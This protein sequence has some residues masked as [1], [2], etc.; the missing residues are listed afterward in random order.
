M[1]PGG[2]T[3]LTFRLFGRD[4]NASRALK[5]V[6]READ[7]AGNKLARLKLTGLGLRATA[8]GG[9]LVALPGTLN[10][11]GAAAVGTAGALAAL[12][13]VAAAGGAALGALRL[14]TLGFADALKEIRDPAKFAEQLKYLSPAARDA[15]RGIRSLLPQID[16][17]RLNVQQ[18]FF[19][20]FKGDLKSLAG[21]YLPMLREQLSQIAANVGAGGHG[22][23]DFLGKPAQVEQVRKVLANTGT[24]AGILGQALRPA[25]DALVRLT[26]TGSTFLPVMATAIARA[27][28]ALDQF[29]AASQKSGA[30]QQ[31]MADGINFAGQLGT[32]LLAVGRVV[33]GVFSAAS[34][35]GFGGFADVLTRIAGIVNGPAFQTG[36]STVFGGL[37]SA[38]ASLS[39]VLPQVGSALAAIA[40]AI[41]S[42]VAGFGSGLAATLA[43]TAQLVVTLAPT[44]NALAAAFA[45]LAPTVGPAVAGFLAIQRALGPAAKALE[46]II[47]LGGKLGSLVVAIR[48]VATAFRFLGLALNVNPIFL[49]ITAIGLLAIG[50]YEAYQ[51]SETFRVVVQTAFK[52]AAGV[53]L[54]AVSAILGA[55]SRLF[56]AASHIPGIGRA[57]ASTAGAFASAKGWIDSTR[58]SIAAM[59]THVGVAVDV[60]YNV[61]VSGPAGILGLGKYGGPGQGLGVLAPVGGNV[62]VGKKSTVGSISYN[63][64]LGVGKGFGQG[65]GKGIAKTKDYTNNHFVKAARSLANK[66]KNAMTKLSDIV[67]ARAA[68]IKQIRDALLASTAITGFEK[69]PNR[70]GTPGAD[71][72]IAYLKRR[73]KALRA[74]AAN[75]NR[76]RKLGLNKTTLQQI[77][78]AGL[79]GGADDAAALAAGGKGAIKQVNSTQK[80]IGKVAGGLSTNLGNDYFKA[81]IAAAKGLIKGLRSQRSALLREAKH[82]AK[83]LRDA[84]RKE[85]KIKSPSRALAEDGRYTGLGF[86]QGLTSTRPAIN[87]ALTGL[88]RPGVGSPLAPT[89]RAAGAVHHHYELHAGFVDD[90]AGI[91]RKFDSMAKTAKSRGYRPHTL[92]LQRR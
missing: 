23:L 74:Y 59:P 5:K 66:L 87:K 30:L 48:N 31:F 60:A 44:I 17:L 11:V 84:I 61:S 91:L 75:I 67:K 12:P 26:S 13:A 77:I 70:R 85:L 88:S 90:G 62:T 25:A 71:Y 54:G 33:T 36:L 38:A 15:A 52:A 39:G 58:A 27:A 2:N 92:A 21:T 45:S 35:S 28:T 79:E 83:G 37:A 72:Y 32:A 86:L 89:Q 42:V 64:G 19:Q 3:D 69:D 55:L 20:Q 80:Q 65:V 29:I 14:A 49:V 43:T 78:D 4:V 34:G 76:L 8:I 1:P 18:N 40:P 10:L 50:L 46:V 57:M 47:G 81:G 16:N 24:A 68:Y 41:A 63:K 56:S 22:L 7:S 51:H 73:L 53:V 9:G 6:G 82:F